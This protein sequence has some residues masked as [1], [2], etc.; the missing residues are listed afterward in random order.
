MNFIFMSISNLFA[1]SNKFSRM[2]Y[3]EPDSGDPLNMEA[4]ALL[5]KSK[6]EFKEYLKKFMGH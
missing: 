3:K 5:S 4:G 6:D 1:V 2:T